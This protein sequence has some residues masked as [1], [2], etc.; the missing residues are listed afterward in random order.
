MAEIL[1]QN[2]I[3]ALIASLS[4]EASDPRP[5]APDKSQGWDRAPR[6]VRSYD[7]RRP[8]KFSKEQLRTLHVIHENFA[9]L[10]TTFFTANFRTMV[11]LVVGSVDQS[12]YT[13]FI[14]SVHNPSVLCPFSLHPLQGTCVLD[15]NPVV[16]FPM[17]DRM[18]GGPGSA[19]PHV[20]ELT[21][22]EKTVMM[23]VV[24]GTLGALRDAWANI[25]EVR[26]EPAG[27]ETNPIF[28]QVAAPNEIVATIA[29]D[30]RV[31]EHVGVITLCIP[32]LTL[33]PI[34]AKLSAHNW[35]GGAAKDVKPADME[36][37]RK[38]VSRAQ[39]PVAVELGRAHLTLRELLDLGPGDL[40]V[41]NTRTDDPLMVYVGNHGKYTAHAG[42]RR[43][44]VAV[45][46]QE[47]VEKGD[48][49]DEQ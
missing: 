35:F 3:D 40:V 44:R 47:V 22:I 13:E 4:A 15:V 37:L 2:E 11:Q 7:F 29:V 33:E 49:D 6:R 41:L 18:F 30:V 48:L 10:L 21:D 46:V 19:L 16:A 27:I 20:R 39:V 23:R 1:T 14:R 31:G 34:L 24:H 32:H 42:Q 45:E 38:Q 28:V 36:V 26:P 43:G 12:T 5:S 25:A 17:L 8:D 9:R